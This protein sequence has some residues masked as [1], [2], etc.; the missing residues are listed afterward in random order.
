MPVLAGSDVA[1]PH[2]AHGLSL[3]AELGALVDAGLSPRQAL[4]AATAAPAEHFGL[5]D[6]G[7]LE[8][9][10]RADLVLVRGDPTTCIDVAA[11]IA[12]IW[13]G[14]VPVQRSSYGE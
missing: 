6:R 4:T 8:V 14:G 9:G 11:D 1:A 12:R 2:S 13:R 10:R 5:G 3:H 7:A